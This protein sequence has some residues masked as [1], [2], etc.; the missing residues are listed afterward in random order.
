MTHAGGLPTDR[1]TRVRYVVLGL[2]CALS[3]VTYLDRACF[4]AAARNIASDLGLRGPEDLKWAHT[5]FAIAYGLFE[6]P[7]GRMGDRLGPRGTLLRIVLWWSVFTALTGLIGLRVGDVVLGGLTTL[8]TLR[9]LFGAGEAGAYPNIA[10]ALHNWMPRANWEIAQSL[11]WMSGRL[12]GGLTPLFWA[13]LVQGTGWRGAFVLFGVVGVCWCLA[14]ATLFRNRPSEHPGV[15]EAERAL[16]EIH[17]ATHSAEHGSIPWR[18]L[19]SNPS[20]MALG[21]MYLGITYGWYFNITYLPS[22]LQNRFQPAEGDLLA[23][24][25]KG[26]PLWVGAFGCLAGGLIVRRLARWTGDQGKAR[27]MLGVTALSLCAVS[28]TA[29]IYAPNMH[30]F[31]VCVSGGAL[32]N[33]LVMGASWATCQDLGGRHAGVTAAWMNTMGTIGAALAGWLTGAIVQAAKAAGALQPAVSSGLGSTAATLLGEPGLRA[34]EMNGYE[35]V[36]ASYA[37]VYA[38]AALCWLRIDP[39]RTIE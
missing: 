8:V 21:L 1:P 28:W 19:A 7:A 4:G 27:Q 25:Y 16:I 38:L 18:A 30:L 20:L 5:L 13:L 29:A 26:G 36:F 39:R 22:Y 11:V 34:A 23:A 10:R 33:D 2:V 37:I 15:N 24:M 17:G 14:F 6:I 35:R 12:M 9:F 31:F 3:M 32:L